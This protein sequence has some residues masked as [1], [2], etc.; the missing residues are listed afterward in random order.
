M[1]GAGKL[2]AF[3]LDTK[4][5]RID[6]SG[7]GGAEVFVT[8]ELDVQVSGIGGVTY[9]GDPPR[10]RRD[11]SGLGKIRSGSKHRNL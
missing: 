8:E 9:I 7:I 1:S 11:V 10:V 6:I 5:C 2:Q 4:F 3:K